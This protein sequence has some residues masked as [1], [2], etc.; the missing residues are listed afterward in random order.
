MT[1]LSGA[2]DPIRNA[3]LAQ[4]SIPAVTK[5]IVALIADTP[6]P[7]T[8]SLKAVAIQYAFWNLTLLIHSTDG[9]T[10]V[11]QALEAKLMF[12]LVRCEPWLPYMEDDPEEFLYPFLNK[13]MPNYSAYR[14]V[15]CIIEK[16]LTKI[17]KLGLDA[18]KSQDI[19]LWNAWNSFVEVAESHMEILRSA[20]G[21][22]L[23]AREQCHSATVNPNI[24][25][26]EAQ[27]DW[28]ETVFSRQG[29][30]RVPA[31]RRLFLCS[32]LL[33]SMPNSRLEIWRPQEILQGTCSSTSR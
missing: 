19:P 15:L 17:Q 22:L 26:L 29:S 8:A 33:K 24:S 25:L 10:W 12:A 3:L 9:V 1:V 23:Q 2:C 4:H 14:S 16:S 11:I 21:G 18:G 13:I 31:M 28:S 20:P 27:S 30:W 6:S 32:I 5:I 7:A